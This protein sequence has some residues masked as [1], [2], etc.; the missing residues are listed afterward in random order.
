[1]D[2]DAGV[3]HRE[4]QEDLALNDNASGPEN[5]EYIHYTNVSTVNLP[6]RLAG[7]G[8]LLG[9]A[10]VEDV[11]L[12]G[13][14]RYSGDDVTGVMIDAAE[15]SYTM[16]DHEKQ[17]YW[18]MDFGEAFESASQAMDQANAQLEAQSGDMPPASG[19]QSAYEVEADISFREGDRGTRRG[20]QA[21]QYFIIVETIAS[22]PETAEQNGKFYVVSE[23]WTS[24]SFAG[25]E[26][27]SAFNRK[28]GEGVM[29]SMDGS[30]FGASLNFAGFNDPR[31]GEAMDRMAEQYSRI[32]GTPVET[33]TY[34]VTGPADDDLDLDAVL[35]PTGEADVRSFPG[36]SSTEPVQTQSTMFSTRTFMAN[37]S[38][39]PFDESILGDRG[40][41][42]I[43]SPIEQYLEDAG[44]A[45]Q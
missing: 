33:T 38:A 34:F 19:D 11:Y 24:N 39:E 16:F 44:D 29:E 4:G 3:V 2:E 23:I 13:D 26:T 45:G 30:D 10:T 17:T 43:E 5:A 28:M 25:S 21:Q 14:R 22:D 9:N 7:L 18:T 6:S 37:L 1:V 27:L 20:L 15:T 42:E 32:E 12:H 36:T 35:H 31:M 8:S 40:Y 41:T